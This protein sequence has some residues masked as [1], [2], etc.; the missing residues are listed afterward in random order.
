MLINDHSAYFYIFLVLAAS[1]VKQIAEKKV[2]TLSGAKRT[3]SA[4]KLGIAKKSKSSSAVTKMASPSVQTD[5]PPV[6]SVPVKPVIQKPSALA[7]L[8]SYSDSDSD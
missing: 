2:A 3:L 5:G 7:S 4:S 6:S 8:C 1:N